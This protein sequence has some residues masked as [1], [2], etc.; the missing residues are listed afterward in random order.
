VK[1]LLKW[2]FSKLSID[3]YQ[4]LLAH[5]ILRNSFTS[6][7]SCKTFNERKD[8][9]DIVIKSYIGANNKL[10]YI[11]FGVHEGFS[12]NYFSKQNTNKESI[13][14]GLD[15]FEGLPEDWGTIKKKGA[16]N[17]DGKL[18]SIADVRVSFIKGW[19]QQTWT[20]L[21]NKL[22]SI[23]NFANLVVHY[24]ADLYSSTLFALSKIDILKKP[25]IAIFDEFTGHETRALFDY[26]QAYDAKVEF[27]GK[28]IS[29]SY[30]DQVVCR[31]TPISNNST[32]A[33]Q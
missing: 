8:L 22:L 9:W 3:T 13:F 23:E 29:N 11:E 30:P 5:S 33:Q 4:R 2:I 18:P 19:F 17:T 26:C 1:T 31:I 21:E 15:S 12:L 25:Y 32:V 14:I 28:T 20:S 16:F 6:L 27:L 24:D 10:I 7:S